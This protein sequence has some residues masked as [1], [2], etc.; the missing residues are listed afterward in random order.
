[1]QNPQAW[2][3]LDQE[4]W[5]RRLL[6]GFPRASTHPR[7][8]LSVM[9]S[10]K[11]LLYRA[12]CQHTQVC[13]NL[14][15]R[16][17]QASFMFPCSHSFGFNIS[18]AGEDLRDVLVVGSGPAGLS[19]ALTLA[20]PWLTLIVFDSGVHRNQLAPYTHTLPTW[21][22]RPPK[23]CREAAHKEAFESIITRSSSTTQ[24]SRA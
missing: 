6:D 7:S 22:H 17:F 1:M 23:E 3:W 10:L 5:Q 12:S 21:D 9:K 2:I 19:S 11:E 13:F 20:R 16:G 4:T 8:R 18:M 14:A 24:P 15:T